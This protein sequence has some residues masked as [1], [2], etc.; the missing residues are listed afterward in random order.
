MI[1]ALVRRYHIRPEELVAI[2]R[3]AGWTQ[4]SSTQIWGKADAR[5][6]VAPKYRNPDT[7]ETWAGRGK[8][9]R[10]LVEAEAAGSDRGQ[11]LTSRDDRHQR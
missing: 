2:A 1:A 5:L 8:P 9:P 10:W 6:A 7:G 11:F 3:R 4:D